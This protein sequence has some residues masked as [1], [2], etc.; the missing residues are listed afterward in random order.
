MKLTLTII[1][2]ITIIKN[3]VRC[4]ESFRIHTHIQKAK[5]INESNVFLKVSEMV[6]TKHYKLYTCTRT[7]TITVEEEPFCRK[8]III[9]DFDNVGLR[10]YH[11]ATKQTKPR[12]A[13]SHF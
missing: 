8:E 3:S 4:N 7:H 10:V 1:E 2:T 13:F 12:V 5:H 9:R 6:L 11:E